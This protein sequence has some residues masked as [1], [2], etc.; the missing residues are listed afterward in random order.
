MIIIGAYPGYLKD[1]HTHR[2]S[3]SLLSE[4]VDQLAPLSAG[5]H[6]LPFYPSSGDD[7]FAVDNW[8]SISPQYGTFAELKAI[9]ARRRIIIDGI[10]N[11]VGV[12]H[13]AV[14]GFLNRP[15]DYRK[16]LIA[17]QGSEKLMT[18]LSP[19]DDEVLRRYLIDAE[20]WQV[21]QTFGSSCFD[22]TIM[23]PTLFREIEQHMQLFRS[24]GV[25][26]LRIDACAYFGKRVGEAQFH[27]P[28]G[29][30]I[31]REIGSAASSLGF[32]ILAQL[33]SD[34]RGM[35]YFTASSFADSVHTVD[36]AFPAVLTLALLTG[37]V[38]PLVQHISETASIGGSA[39]RP[40]RTHDGIML[41]SA[42]L[43][44]PVRDKILT[45]AHRW[46]LP[47]RYR[48][49]IPYELN[50][51]LPYLCRV[52]GDSDSMRRRLDLAA[53]VTAFTP[54]WSYFYLPALLGDVPEDRLN[55]RHADDP[56]SVNRAPLPSRL[57]CNLLQSYQIHDISELLGLLLRCH[58]RLSLESEQPAVISEPQ[59]GV[60][61]IYHPS[62]NLLVYGNFHS[63]VPFK[64]PD[65]H[66]LLFQGGRNSSSSSVGPL[67]F[68]CG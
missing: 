48:G 43:S 41:Q 63:S 5:L 30:Q 34:Q 38:S 8:F 26:G 40:M 1:A 12:N 28:A 56:R 22:I 15:K 11:H 60:I 36:Y 54:G 55:I 7:G 44:Q 19:R 39:L 37:E 29:M 59:Q 9:A 17:F 51:S 3:L 68:G 4:L 47:I 67:G 42:R 31:A 65:T 58:E 35:E 32:E 66:Q 2:S 18:P 14:Q 61:S 10:Y 6:L 27:H 23:E 57:E 45:A 64:I 46:S 25:W 33:D 62:A 13:W 53:A 20:T 50:N 16:Y 52:P 49:G 21:W 24:I